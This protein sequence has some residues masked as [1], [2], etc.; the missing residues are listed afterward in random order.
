MAVAFEPEERARLTE[1]ML[2]VAEKL[3]LTQ[4][5]RK[6]SLAELTE[7][8]GIAKSSFYSFFPA[9]ESVYLELMVRRAPELSGRMREAAERPTT[10][11]RLVALMRT[12][13]DLLEN[14]PL[15]RRLITHPDELAAVGRRLGEREL[16]RVRPHVLDPVTELVERAQAEG[17]LVDA[18]PEVVIGVLRTVGLVVA[19]REEYGP[20][21]RDV[22]DLTIEALATGLTTAEGEH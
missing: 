19:H 1:R 2:T 13:A 12:T 16:E 11:D 14:D 15:Y 22:L 18:E 20:A 10:R 4:G 9:K 8:L 5:L 21:Y 7:P 3:F 17:G 6:T